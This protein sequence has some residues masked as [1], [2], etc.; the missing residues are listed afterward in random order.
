MNKA[1][2]ERHAKNKRSENKR[3]RNNTRYVSRHQSLM[4]W[5]TNVR[6]CLQIITGGFWKILT[7]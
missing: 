1:G 5:E 7:L 3:V 2:F 6:I 4:R